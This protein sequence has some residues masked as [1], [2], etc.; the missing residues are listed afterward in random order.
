[1]YKNS[2]VLSIF[3][4][5]NLFILSMVLC[6]FM[7]DIAAFVA[8]E[9]PD[10]PLPPLTAEEE[11]EIPV[12][13]FFEVELPQ[14]ATPPFLPM[15]TDPTDQTVDC[16]LNVM[17]VFD[18][19]GSISGSEFS[20]MK[21]FAVELVDSFTIGP[22]AT[23]VGF[24][25]FSSTAREESPLVPD[26]NT[27]RNEILTMRQ[28]GGNTDI[29]AGISLG[30]AGLQASDRTT[31]RDVM[32]VL[33]D[34]NHNGSGDPVAEA[35][36]ARAQGTQIFGITV[37]NGAN[38][39]LIDQISGG[40]SYDA[41]NFDELE[42]I[43]DDLVTG[44]CAFSV[45]EVLYNEF[46]INNNSLIPIFPERGSNNLTY[47]GNRVRISA[48]VK[49]NGANDQVARIEFIDGDTG[50]RLP[51]L[52]D[53]SRDCTREQLFPADA[54]TTVHCIW[55]TSG[56]A[57]LNEQYPRE[58][59]SVNVQVVDPTTN[60]AIAG[61]FDD[62]AILE[63]WPRPVVLVH[64][65]W[66]DA[67]VWTPYKEYLRA[68]HPNWRGYA[69]GD[70]QYPG[71]M[72]TGDYALDPN[73]INSLRT[74]AS[75]MNR[76]VTNLRNS[77]NSQ[78]IDIVAHSMGGLISR[79]YVQSWMPE[80]HGRPAAAN[81]FM[82]GTPH[83]GS[84]CAWTYNVPST[85]ELRPEVLWGFNMAVRD[86]KGVTFSALA[87]DALPVTPCF[88]PLVELGALI[89]LYGL[90]W[91]D[92]RLT[93]V[94]G[95]NDS[96]VSVTSALAR[97]N[98]NNETV[99]DAYH[100]DATS[101]IGDWL[102]SPSNFAIYV[103]PQ[104]AE[105]P[106]GSAPPT[107]RDET[108]ET[109]PVIEISND[110][111]NQEPDGVEVVASETLTIAPG[112]TQTVPFT[113]S[114]SGT[115]GASVSAP[116]SVGSSLVA[117]DGTVVDSIAAGSAEA[118]LWFRD[119]RT[120]NAAVGVW[121]VRLENTGSEAA[122]V[123][124]TAWAENV[125]GTLRFIVDG[126]NDQN[127]I[128]V[129]AT[130]DFD[131]TPITGATVEAELIDDEGN[132]QTLTLVDTGNGVDVTADDGVYT[133]RSN[134]LLPSG[135]FMTITALLDNFT[136]TGSYTFEIIE[137]DLSVTSSILD[138]P[139]V[140]GDRVRY[141][142]TVENNGPTYADGIVLDAT[143]PDTVT[144][145][146]ITGADCSSTAQGQRC[147]LAAIPEDASTTVIFETSAIPEGTTSLAFSSTVSA[148]TPDPDTTN[149]ASDVQ[150][151]VDSPSANDEQANALVVDALPYQNSQGTR[152]ATVS[153]LDPVMGCGWNVTN[154]VWYQYTATTNEVI[155]FST[156]GS[157]FDTVLAIFKAEDDGSLIRLDCANQEG[158]TQTETLELQLTLG[159]TYYAV[160]GGNNA[161]FGRLVFSV[162][163][164]PA[165]I[166]DAQSNAISIPSL[167]FT[168][169]RDTFAATTE[170]TDPQ[171]SCVSSSG[172]NIWYLYES[173]SDATQFEA[174]PADFDT[175][176]SVWEDTVDG[177]VEIGCDDD[178]GLG[179]NSLVRVRT[180]PNTTYYVMVSGFRNEG[181]E[182]TF[183]ASDV[184]V[185]LP[186][187]DLFENA[188]AIGGLPFSDVQNTT[189]ATLSDTDPI[190]DCT[191]NNGPNI[192]YSYTPEASGG[193]RF[194]TES[195]D[196]DTVL[197]VYTNVSGDLLQLYC[198]NDNGPDTSS[199]V[200]MET[201]AG[202]TYF[203]AVSGNEGAGG[204][205]QL[206]AVDI[207]RYLLPNDN[208]DTAIEITRMPYAISQNTLFASASFDDPLASCTTNTTSP[209]VW[210]KL[211]IPANFTAV[212]DTTGS[213]YEV[214]M[215]VYQ[216][217]RDNLTEIACDAAPSRFTGAML[218]VPIEADTDYFVMLR[219]DSSFGSQSGNLVFNVFGQDQVYSTIAT[220]A[221]GEDDVYEDGR[222]V[223]QWAAAADATWYNISVTLPNGQ[224]SDF[225]VETSDV[226]RDAVCT[227]RTYDFEAFGQHNWSIRGYSDGGIGNWSQPIS[228]N[229]G[230][231][232]DFVVH[233]N[234]LDGDV[235]TTISYNDSLQW[236]ADAEAVWYNVYMTGP[237]NFQLNEWYEASEVCSGNICTVANLSLRNGDYAWYLAGW[238]QGGIGPYE[239]ATFTLNIPVP[240]AVQLQEP[241]TDLETD[242]SWVNDPN[243]IWY[244]FSLSN[245]TATLRDEWF[246]A[247]E[248]CSVNTCTLTEYLATGDYSVS[249]QAWGPGG[250]GEVTTLAFTVDL[251]EVPAPGILT[252]FAPSNAALSQL[253]WRANSAAIWY[254]IY[255][256]GSDGFVYEEWYKGSE[257]CNQGVCTVTSPPLDNGEFD[258]WLAG[259]GPGGLGEYINTPFT[260]DVDAPGDIVRVFPLDSVNSNDRVVNL[261]WNSDSAAVWYQVQ[262]TGPGEFTFD[263]WVDG[264]VACEGTTCSYQVVLPEY[265]SYTWTMTAWGPVGLGSTNETTFSLVQP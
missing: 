87:G 30:Q 32:L 148:N 83:L 252:T 68:A 263:E 97:S 50:Q 27:I 113:I 20:T 72:D 7:I 25:Q 31:V 159:E 95:P 8:Q 23:Q 60:I 116:V 103:E 217:T 127:R 139:I 182:V 218:E 12:D 133:V 189:L 4:A 136:R 62:P 192:W 40:N 223:F 112:A 106:W 237:D 169:S 212:M 102:Y 253:S 258:W 59:M 111:A 80:L 89:Y 77:L 140:V 156:A 134:P 181:G 227:T 171:P 36:A 104:L 73:P 213:S 204:I 107:L 124:V 209:T 65:I 16:S 45:E 145:D 199:F 41:A 150:T 214:A 78:H 29:A 149:N 265:G 94:Y 74:N 43:L 210:F 99:I 63:I 70:G 251:S 231:V 115:I 44:S 162:N 157:N 203:I 122:D 58:E 216:G 257:I 137:A 224:I 69:V 153:D 219:G 167:P 166:N 247:S 186:S 100:T 66:S 200:D 208:F 117:P 114:Q 146:N 49:N 84:A 55:D 57:W 233:L 207:T 185:A 187:N 3:T 76:Y 191:V 154:T 48:T 21:T 232:P 88:V 135:Y 260:I 163:F 222:V 155:G 132:T 230:P 245:G 9:D 158:P 67:S 46:D 118:G 183:T 22:S 144:V 125:Q 241:L 239:L 110:T 33:T 85:E 96:V 211:N 90:D 180:N 178:S 175:V 264:Q 52:N 86:R 184:S 176:I 202:E 165:P 235:L 82:L 123:G 64:G 141:S 108:P 129:T 152:L 47:D 161:D 54:L 262:L 170:F 91:V 173:I 51:L 196:F 5:R 56:F 109:I 17:M 37:G 250:L 193:T 240:A 142:V 26:E 42:K 98:N 236:Q 147:N 143:I 255:V 172:K 13:E 174:G 243:A 93:E 234:P 259:W 197:S 246:R 28:M 190:P 53:G 194:T 179:D 79:Q 195:S 228:F 6:I 71:V 128:T 215:V 160:L 38:R 75:I 242:F 119:H 256:I 220:I 15:N 151:N 120:A 121:T 238:A 18:G 205:A 24:V 138:R 10:P 61:T 244:N 92:A 1:M 19:S 226:C 201:V 261:I 198:N 126:P 81:L 177:L 11:A 249:S 130:L 229:V 2:K 39:A 248:I 225:W 14:T 35:N 105:Y 131:G 188:I 164:A 221:P 254:N 168:D 206:R 34:G 101:A